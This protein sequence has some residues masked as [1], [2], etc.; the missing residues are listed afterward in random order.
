MTAAD[1]QIG[2]SW[3]ALSKEKSGWVWLNAVDCGGSAEQY[4]KEFDLPVVESTLQTGY[5]S[6]PKVCYVGY[7]QQ[8]FI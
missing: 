7:Q 5:L 4:V 2:Q 6:K 8:C 1:D 3:V